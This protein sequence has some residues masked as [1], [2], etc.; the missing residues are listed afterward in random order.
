M[1]KPSQDSA[2]WNALSS[3]HQATFWQHLRPESSFVA[4]IQSGRL[5]AVSWVV[6]SSQYDTGPTALMCS[7]E[8]HVVQQLNALMQSPLWRSTAV[9]LTWDD[10]GGFYDHVR[11][12]RFDAISFGPRVADIVIS[13]YARSGY[14]DHTTYDF[15]SILRYI[16][17]KYHL[18]HLSAFDRH[19]TSIA[20]SFDFGWQPLPPLVLRER[21][22]TS[23]AIDA[24]ALQGFSP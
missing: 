23:P 10:F 20:R 17:D 11:P 24:S 21:P 22:C 13:P 9:F 16:E 14:V 19:A 6:T 12:P 2:L 5:P 1:P 4:D 8:N 18:P 7:G 3:P 15:T